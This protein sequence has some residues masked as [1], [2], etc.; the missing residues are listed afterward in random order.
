VIVFLC[1]EDYND[2]K[3]IKLHYICNGRIN[4]NV[5]LIWGGGGGRGNKYV[6][7]LDKM[8]L[9]DILNMLIQ[10]IQWVPG[11]CTPWVKRPGHGADH[12]SPSSVKVKMNGAILRLHQY[13]MVWCL[14][15]HTDNFTFTFTF[16]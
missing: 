8:H 9:A 11:A 15:K 14:V 2:I 13:V 6:L 7:S 12:S 4:F 10:S 16:T 3:C 5:G 1:Q